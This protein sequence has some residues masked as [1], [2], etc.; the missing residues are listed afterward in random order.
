ML[1]AGAIKQEVP[2][3]KQEPQDHDEFT[4]NIFVKTEERPGTSTGPYYSRPLNTKVSLTFFANRRSGHVQSEKY[5]GWAG[6]L[7]EGG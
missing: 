3:I 5:D 7:E 4:P 2:E 1:G 6:A